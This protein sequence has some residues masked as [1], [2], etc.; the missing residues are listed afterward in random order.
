[1]ERTEEPNRERAAAP[2][3]RR[4]RGPSSR[5]RPW[6]ARDGIRQSGPA[7]RR[8]PRGEVSLRRELAEFFAAVYQTVPSPAALAYLGELEP[9]EREAA[10][11]DYAA[12][13]GDR[14][15]VPPLVHRRINAL[16][17]FV[18]SLPPP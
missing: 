14:G 17:R 15:M 8:P 1:M 5:S 4:R 7:V 10:L 18:A 13:L 2:G 9:E 6:V 3:S 16:R 12:H 11:F